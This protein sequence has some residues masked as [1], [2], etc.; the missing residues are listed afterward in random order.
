MNLL[1]EAAVDGD[2]VGSLGRPKALIST[3]RVRSTLAARRRGQAAAAGDRGL[4]PRARRAQA[5][6]RDGA[7]PVR[8]RPAAAR[9]RAKLLRF[10]FEAVIVDLLD[11][12][13]VRFDHAT[14]WL[15]RDRGPLRHHQ[16]DHD[17][18]R[19]RNAVPLPADFLQAPA[20]VAARPV[21]RG[22]DVARG[23]EVHHGG[24][25]GGREEWMSQPVG[26]AAAESRRGV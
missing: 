1:H 19:V 21:A 12:V 23:R 11:G 25:R 3:R 22:T 4:L 24:A 5:P 13:A 10:S 17:G 2:D 7:R 6:L 14:H 20:D 9:A 8:P 15:I 26:D 18:A 16:E